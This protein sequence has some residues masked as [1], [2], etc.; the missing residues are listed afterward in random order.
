MLSPNL[1]PWE[2]GQVKDK[3]H[4]DV[5]FVGIKMEALVEKSSMKNETPSLKTS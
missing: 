5:M 2:W 4:D 3:Q 1:S